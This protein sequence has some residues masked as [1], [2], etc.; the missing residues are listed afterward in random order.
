MHA[1]IT[2]VRFQPGAAD[3]ATSIYR[4]I[5]LPAASEQQGFR[6]ALAFRSNSQPEKYIIISLWETEAD[7]LAS[8]PPEDILPLLQPLEK[9]VAES[10]QDTYE[11]LFQID[12]KSQ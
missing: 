3:E 2:S 10:N 1:R 5:M 7:M 6:S 12:G 4:D 11:M 9:L 8:R